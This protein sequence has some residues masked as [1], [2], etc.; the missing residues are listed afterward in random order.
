MSQTK[1][2]QF[3]PKNFGALQVFGKLVNQWMNDP[4][5]NPDLVPVGAGRYKMSVENFRK[6]LTEARLVG[7]ASGGAE[8]DYVI[9]AD[10]QWIEL[11]M[12]RA[13][14]FEVLLPEVGMMLNS[15]EP[16]QIPSVYGLVDYSSATPLQKNSGAFV[17]YQIPAGSYDAFLQPYMAAY[18]CSQCA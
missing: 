10:V 4:S 17:D 15:A 18:M 6:A 8:P 2:L 16:L 5:N 7:T 11:V 13:D 9:R 3:T 12:R 1:E 14:V